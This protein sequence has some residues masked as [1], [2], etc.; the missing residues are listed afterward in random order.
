MHTSLVQHNG[1]TNNHFGSTNADDNNNT[2]TSYESEHKS[3]D[4]RTSSSTHCDRI[5]SPSEMLGTPLV[6]DL[7]SDGRLDIMYNV[8][9]S[10]KDTPTRTL[11]VATDLETMF[12]KTYGKGILDFDSFQPSGEQPWTQFM[13]R[14]GDCVFRPHP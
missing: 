2:R 12:E 6:G 13:G 5:S 7:N 4:E 9:W 11:V 1:N 10:T 8:V 3:E 14:D